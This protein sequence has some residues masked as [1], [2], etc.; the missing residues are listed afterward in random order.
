MG[1][2]CVC[3]CTLKGKWRGVCSTTVAFQGLLTAGYLGFLERE[4]SRQHIGFKI[5]AEMITY[6]VPC[7]FTRP[8]LDACIGRS[9]CMFPANQLHR[10]MGAAYPLRGY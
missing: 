1:E 7:R 9:S 10:V 4:G 6:F 8:Y 5:C 3:V 2:I